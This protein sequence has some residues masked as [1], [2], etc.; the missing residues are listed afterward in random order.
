M[1][2]CKV[3]QQENFTSQDSLVLL[4]GIVYLLSIGEVSVECKNFAS[5]LNIS[6]V[7]NELISKYGSPNITKRS[8]DKILSDVNTTLGS[9]MNSSQV[10]F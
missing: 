2:L 1:T 6:S 4:S 3:D 8:L 10:I 5:V 9:Y 7:H